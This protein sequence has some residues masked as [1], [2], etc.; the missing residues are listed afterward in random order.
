M[1][2]KNQSAVWKCLEKGTVWSL[3]PPIIRFIQPA[4]YALIVNK[5]NFINISKQNIQF[6]F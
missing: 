3:P 1:D 5:S 6:Y 2:K 4:C